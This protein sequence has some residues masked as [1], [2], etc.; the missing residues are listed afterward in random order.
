[1]A[2]HRT[3]DDITNATEHVEPV[4]PLRALID[5]HFYLDGWV[6]SEGGMALLMMDAL[7]FIP[8]MMAVMFYPVQALIGL[9]AA[10]VLSLVLYEGFV[11]YRRHV[12]R[13]HT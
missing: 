7:L 12:R 10:L 11:L 3:F 8:F 13:T 5:H 1:M 4:H 9:G 6:S 2:H